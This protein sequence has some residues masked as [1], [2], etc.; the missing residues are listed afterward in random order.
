VVATDHN[1]IGIYETAQ[2]PLGYVWFEMQEQAQTPFTCASRRI[3][4]HHISVDEVMRRR[5]VASALVEW[6]EAYARSAGVDEVV[7]DHWTANSQ[8]GA[9]FSQCDFAPMRTV[10]HKRLASVR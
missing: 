5:G 3:Y 8:A 1:L 10:L 9:F 7:V 2:M 6:V 4:I